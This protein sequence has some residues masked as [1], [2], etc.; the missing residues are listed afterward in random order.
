LARLSER[1]VT[2]RASASPVAVISGGSSGIGLEVARILRQRGHHLHLLARDT[3]RLECARVDLASAGSNDISLHALDVADAA[4]CAAV[5]AS[6]MA[7]RGRIDWLV[8][9]AGM[10][11]P[12]L[13]L[14]QPPEAHHRQMAVNYFGTLNLVHPVAGSMAAGGGGCITLL[15]SAVS[16]G[17]V[18]GL[19]S[20]SASKFAISGLAETLHLELAGCGIRVSLACPPDTDTPQLARERAERPEVTNIIADGGGVMSAADVARAV[21]EGTLAGRFLIAPGR[22]MDL[23]SRFHSLFGP[24][25]RWRQKRIMAKW[26]S[27]SRSAAR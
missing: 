21:V 5:V 10:V 9:S 26:Q 6:I 22:L 14:D 11:E 27:R 24:L 2:T 15:G 23:Y 1:G 8:T 7:Q 18:I 4:A 19:G 12:G 17:A 13:F 20:Y 3:A 25:L 16:F